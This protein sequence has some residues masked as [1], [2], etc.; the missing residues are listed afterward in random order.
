M[1]RAPTTTV[2]G[3]GSVS[4][5]GVSEARVIFLCRSVVVV[6]RQTNF[7][8]NLAR[9]PAYFS[10]ARFVSGILM[11][12]NGF[13]RVQ[14]GRYSKITAVFHRPYIRRE[15]LPYLEVDFFY[16]F[17]FSIFIQ[18]TPHIRYPMCKTLFNLKS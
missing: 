10:C 12:Q 5:A 4:N 7:F 14:A 2:A 1:A 17:F 3:G 11:H 9:I 16:K 8:F 6:Q 15:T 13:H 18:K